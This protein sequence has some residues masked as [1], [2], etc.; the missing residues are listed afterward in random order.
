MIGVTSLGRD[1]TL[2]VHGLGYDMGRDGTHADNGS[3]FGTTS[4]GFITET[5][6]I[7]RRG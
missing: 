5:A 1:D 3:H 4:H 6:E 7:A 2:M